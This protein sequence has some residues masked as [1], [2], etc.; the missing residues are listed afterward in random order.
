MPLRALWFDM[1]VKRSV[2]EN[3]KTNSEI[4]G[5]TRIREDDHVVTMPN[6][7]KPHMSDSFSLEVGSDALFNIRNGLIT[8]PGFSDSLLNAQCW[9][10]DFLQ[11]I[12]S[13]TQENSSSY[14]EFYD[15][16]TKTSTKTFSDLK[17]QS[18]IAMNRQT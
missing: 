17:E 4:I 2:I 7:V 11:L 1:S 10:T 5:F 14:K 18:A 3:T 15:S 8:I 12:S 13:R 16:I 9:K 6:Y